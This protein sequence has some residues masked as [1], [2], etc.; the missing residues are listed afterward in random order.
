MKSKLTLQLRKKWNEY[1][2]CQKHTNWTSQK[3]YI[4][5]NDDKTS[6][7]NLFSDRTKL[8]FLAMTQA[9]FGVY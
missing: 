8:I 2:T 6:D 7:F 1:T 3:G 9:H 4:P 5:R